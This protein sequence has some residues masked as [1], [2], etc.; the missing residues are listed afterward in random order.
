VLAAQRPALARLDSLAAWEA[1]RDA[2]PAYHDAQHGR[3]CPIGSLAAKAAAT[4]ARRDDAPP[5]ERPRRR[6]LRPAPG[7]AAAAADAHEQ[8]LWPLEAAL[9]QLRA[10]L[11][12][13][14]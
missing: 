5:P 2:L 10:A 1:W 14:G 12:S 13:A 4:D 7:R 11:A 8:A 6:A 3:G 9:V